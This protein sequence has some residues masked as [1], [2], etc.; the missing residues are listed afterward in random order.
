M[1]TSDKLFEGTLTVGEEATP[2]EFSSAVTKVS[3]EPKVDDG[4]SIPVLD[5]TEITDEGDEAWSL[6]G[7][8]LQSYGVGS[9]LT[10]VNAAYRAAVTAAGGPTSVPF[11]LK[12]KTAG[13]LTV[14]GNIWLRPV[15]IGGDVKKRNTSEFEFPLDGVP[16]FAEDTGGV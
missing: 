7:E 13:A 16:V 14:T 11:S 4:D 2:M 9:L 10:K 12:P 6:K 3:V 5:G 8:F 1:A 15:M